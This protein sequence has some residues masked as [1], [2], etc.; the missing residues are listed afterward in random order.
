[1][2]VDRETG[3]RLEFDASDGRLKKELK[4]FHQKKLLDL[5]DLLRKS[6]SQFF[7]VASN[8]NVVDPLSVYLRGHRGQRS[9]PR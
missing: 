6:G 1:M 4:E 2:V 9:L 8:Q 3:E 5:N 7:S